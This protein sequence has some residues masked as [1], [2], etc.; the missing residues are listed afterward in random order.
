[1]VFID[2][3]GFLLL[4]LHFVDL[5]LLSIEALLGAN[6]RVHIVNVILALEL[7]VQSIRVVLDSLVVAVCF[8]NRVSINIP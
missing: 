5:R 7:I 2:V 8:I 3:I 1:M 6:F 4:Q